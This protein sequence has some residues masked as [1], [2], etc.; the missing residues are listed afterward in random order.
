QAR[1][2]FALHGS[3]TVLFEV[4][5]KEPEYGY[6]QEQIDL[7]ERGLLGIAEHMADGSI[8][9]LNGDDFYKL[10][11]YWSDSPSPS[12]PMQYQTDF[13]DDELAK[14]PSGWTHRWLGDINEWKIKDDPIRLQHKSGSGRRG[15]TI[16][17]IGAVYGDA[18][19]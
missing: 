8:N 13:S 4:P 18:E 10:P 2:A 5:G 16:D 15:L 17:S 3:G 19:V 7:V 1:S 11:K 6:D 9:D 12:K 14:S